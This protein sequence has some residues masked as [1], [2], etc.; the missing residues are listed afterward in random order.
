M[1]QFQVNLLTAWWEAAEAI[2]R[3]YEADRD[4]GE[5]TATTAMI[6][7]LVIAAIAAGGVIAAKIVA[8]AENVP[9]P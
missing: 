3:R 6:V 5:I 8:N 9:E 7:I 2:E 1:L 4:R